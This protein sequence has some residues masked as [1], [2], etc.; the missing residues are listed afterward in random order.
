[1]EPPE[2]SALASPSGD[3]SARA[4]ALAY[5]GLAVSQEWN[6]QGAEAFTNF[7]R[8]AELAPDN[9]ELQFRV[10]L[11]YIREQQP[12]QARAV[13]QR[14]AERR[15]QS[16]RAQLW[17]AFVL[18]ITG[19]PEEALPFFDRAIKVA[20]GNAL[21]YLEKAALLVR[22]EDVEGAVQILRQGLKKADERHDIAR[23]LG[24]LLVRRAAQ[25]PSPAAVEKEASAALKDLA[26]VLEHEPRDEALLTQ[27][28]L[29]NKLA[30]Q[31]EAALETLEQVAALS[32]REDRW[33]QRQLAGLFTPEDLPALLAAMERLVEK[34]PTN[35]TRLLTLGHLSEQAGKTEPAESAYR[36]A[37]ELAPTDP[38]PL[39]RLGLLLAA[40]N[41]AGDAEALFADAIARMPDQPYFHEMLAFIELSKTNAP[42]A[43]PHFDR[44]AELMREGDRAP[45][46][47]HFAISHVVANLLASRLDEAGRR[48]MEAFE[49]DERSLD[50]FVRVLIRED[51]ERH[52]GSGIQVLRNLTEQTSDNPP[53]WVALGLLNSYAKRYPDA[54]AAFAKAEDLART[55]DA[56]A[57]ALSASFYFWYGAACERD[58]QIDRAAELFKKCIA[59]KPNPAQRE[60]FNAY[61]DAMNYLAYMWAERGLELEQSLELIN[62]ALELRPNNPAFIDTRGW[63]YFMQGRYI[64]ARD[65]IERAIALLPDDPTLTD[66]LGDI[67]EKLDVIEEAIDWWTKSFILDPTNEKVGAKLIRN[68][69]DL[70]PLRE[71]AGALKKQSTTELPVVDWDA[72]ASEAP[73]EE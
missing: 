68:G 70:E 37:A 13:M 10:A 54:I 67:Y 25:Q 28:A 17:A 53:L 51:D 19:Q 6:R 63:I 56:D 39:L 73:A 23:M 5:Y 34:A 11:G 72:D 45:L 41:R 69:V 21:P 12:E 43:L 66:H 26:S 32:H 3:V 36:R 59:L 30:G 61:V 40:Q 58:G 47:P 71:K 31:Y 29:L 20:P 33:R 9:E 46:T 27:V 65:E 2:S 35:A 38:A 44:A 14:L 57:Q 7:V 60:D 62:K 49:S 55:T 64:E 4:S 42:A 50:T 22:L 8:A 48:L 16:D 15:P 18:R 52:M 24:E 1:M